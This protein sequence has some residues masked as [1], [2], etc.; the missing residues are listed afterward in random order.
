MAPLTH[1]DTFTV[2]LT[3]AA[4]RDRV[5]TWFRPYAHRVV[6]DTVD[7]LEVASG[8]QAKMRLLGGAFIAASSLPT[9]TV[10]SIVPAGAS[11]TV[12]V[13]ARDAVGFG[14]KTGMKHKY[15]E[16]IASIVDGLRAALT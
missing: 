13:T 9:R 12:E 14:V 10:V 7:Q 16:W 11:S 6:V 4:V 1:T 8:S 15:E 3:P 5:L 2:T